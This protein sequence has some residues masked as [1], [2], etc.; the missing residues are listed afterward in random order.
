MEILWVED[1]PGDEV[2]IRLALSGASVPLNLHFA[3][4]GEQALRLIGRTGFRPALIVLDLN[5]P[6]IPGPDLLQRWRGNDIPMVVF[7]SSRNAAERALVLALG[8]REFVEKPTGIEAFTSAVSGIVERWH[9][10]VPQKRLW[11]L[12]LGVGSWPAGI[13]GQKLL[14]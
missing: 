8:A 7:S 13:P 10:G 11:Q 2:L 1:N 9:E 14:P 12:I 5:I 6:R 3:R 4:D